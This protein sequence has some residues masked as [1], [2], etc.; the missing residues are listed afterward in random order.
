MDGDMSHNPN[1]LNRMIA[2]L[3]DNDIVMGSR[4]ERWGQGGKM[5]AASQ[6]DFR[7]RGLYG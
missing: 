6:N 3:I 5:G 4:F 2:S 1:I 7:S